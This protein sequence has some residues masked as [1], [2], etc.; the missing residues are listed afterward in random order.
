[1]KINIF[2]IIFIFYFFNSYAEQFVYPVADFNNGNQYMVIHQKS[3]SDIELWI[4]NE[5]TG[6]A[7]K[8]LSSFLVPA[9]LRMMPCGKGFSF[10]DQ[11]YIKIKEFEK[12][13]PKT[14]P[15]YEPIGLF[16]N[17][18]W[19]DD[20][21]FYFVARQGDF[22]QIFQSDVQANVSRLTN[23]PA[24]ALYPQKI[25]DRL[26]YIKRDMDFCMTIIEKPW[27]PVSMDC[28]DT[29]QEQIIVE[30][31]SAAQLCFLHMMN[32]REGFYIQ[33][34]TKK[35]KNGQDCYEFACFYLIKNKNWIT[36]KLFSYKIPSK[37]LMGSSRLH[38]SLEPF[39]PNYN[40]QNNI[41]FV[42][43]Q[44][45]LQKFELYTYNIVSESI[46]KMS[47]QFLHRNNNQQIFAPYIHG[48]KIYCGFIIPDRLDIK[49]APINFITDEQHLELP[50]FS[51]K[52]QFLT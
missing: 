48:D 21:T 37:Y 31:T 19:I 2:L 22:F 7:T 17:M 9:N 29:L 46:E 24:D 12:R 26:F 43:W 11:G 44:Q 42:N 35:I 36:K 10:I 32:E 13:S 28:T 40:A 4:V 47:D 8:G 18:N 45:E 51:N 25:G 23:E 49:S 34:P 33:A 14:L 15:I 16:S 3:L 39:L 30:E 27:N 5:S 6:Y 41:Y 52:K 50:F 38:E 20:E 1:M